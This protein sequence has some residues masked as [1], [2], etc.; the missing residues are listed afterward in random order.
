MKK[1]L[2]LALLSLIAACTPQELPVAAIQTIDIGNISLI[3][4]TLSY[5]TREAIPTPYIVVI[6]LYRVE[7][8]SLQLIATTDFLEEGQV[9]VNYMLAFN[10]DLVNTAT[11]SYLINARFLTISGTTIYEA[12]EMVNPFSGNAGVNLRMQPTGY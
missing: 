10:A 11:G 12:A 4:G 3:Q 2:A 1:L 7:G 9:P 6:E 8:E 5:L